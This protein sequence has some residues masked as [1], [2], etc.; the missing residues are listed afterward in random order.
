[1]Q[2]L[3]HAMQTLELEPAAVI[4]RHLHNRSHR[5]RVMCRQHRIEHI[6]AFQQFLRAG[7]ET[8]IRIRLARVNRVVL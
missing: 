6:T 7:Q 5:M 1:M 2:C 8:Q 4:A 3:A